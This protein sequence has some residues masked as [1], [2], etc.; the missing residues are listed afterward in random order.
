MATGRFFF[1][2]TNARYAKGSSLGWLE[3]LMRNKSPMYEKSEKNNIWNHE[4]GE[5]M[6]KFNCFKKKRARVIRGNIFSG[7]S[8]EMRKQNLCNF[9]R[10][11]IEKQ[12]SEV[13]KKNVKNLDVGQKMKKTL[14]LL[15]M[16][17]R[18][19]RDN[20][21]LSL[22]TSMNLRRSSHSS[23]AKIV[24]SLLLLDIC[25]FCEM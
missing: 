23:V 20:L 16:R 14:I 4:L 17:A 22:N 19:I 18:A 6:C 9:V 11:K 5:K 8:Q 3:S 7:Y 2:G 12:V 21:K 1:L 24:H 15:R 10:V 13:Q 25:S